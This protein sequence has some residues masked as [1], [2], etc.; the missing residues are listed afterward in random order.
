ML[1]KLR[2]L[3]R[4]SYDHMH[5]RRHPSKRLVG[6]DCPWHILLD[7]AKAHTIVVSGGVGND[8]SFELALAKDYGWRIELYDPSPTGIATAARIENQHQQIHFH[9]IGI[10]NVDG[11]LKFGLPNNPAEG[12]YRSGAEGETVEF[13]CTSLRRILDS[14][15]SC[16]QLIL[17]IDIEGFEYGLFEA[18]DLSVLGRFDQICVEFHHFMPG[19]SRSQTRAAIEKLRQAGFVTIHKTRCDFLFVNKRLL[20]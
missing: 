7:T 16:D 13:E 4:R 20:Q 2:N 5:S 15:P 9:P 19:F 18:A 10:A 1:R 14:L 6:G 17:K 3:L 8:M 11:A 12:S